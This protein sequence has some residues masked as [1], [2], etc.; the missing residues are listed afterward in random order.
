MMRYDGGAML[1]YSLAFES[2]SNSFGDISVCWHDTGQSF[3][4][5]TRSVIRDIAHVCHRR[6]SGR[7]NGLLRFGNLDA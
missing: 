1:C 6:R 4:D 5:G 3:H 7:G 2:L